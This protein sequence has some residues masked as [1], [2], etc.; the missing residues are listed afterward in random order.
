MPTVGLREFKNKFSKYVA[1][2][3][4][5]EKVSITDRGQ[6]V[7]ELS[8]ARHPAGTDR[9]ATTVDELRRKGLLSGTGRNSATLYPA[10][11]RTLK[12]SVSALLDEERGSR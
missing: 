4:A 5:G 10:M 12:R 1:R 9:P 7:A 3:K 2:A 8:P 6:V 11:P